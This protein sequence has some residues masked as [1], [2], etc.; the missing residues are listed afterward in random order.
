ML[1]TIAQARVSAVMSGVILRRGILQPGAVIRSRQRRSCEKGSF[2]TLLSLRSRGSRR[3]YQSF[4]V[5]FRNFAILGLTSAKTFLISAACLR[6]TGAI[7]SLPF[8]VSYTTR[9]RR[10]SG[11]SIRLTK[12]LSKRR[13][14]ATLIEPGVRFTF[15]PIVFTGRGPLFRRASSMRKSVSSS[16][17]SAIP[18]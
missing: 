6:K 15:G 7:N 5:W 12:P 17:V 2:K 8:G 3:A 10:S 4:S 9:T 1:R 13:S 16:P 18:A 14:T 11:L